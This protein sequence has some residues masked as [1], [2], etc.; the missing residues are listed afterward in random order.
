VCYNAPH[1]IIGD[2]V[3][4]MSTST[5]HLLD[6]FDRLPDAEKLEVASEILRRT[7]EFQL[8]PLS[9]EELVLNAAEVFLELDQREMEHDQP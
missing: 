2:E 6:S 8:P 9:D 7:V 1:V 3:I 4:D 5:Q